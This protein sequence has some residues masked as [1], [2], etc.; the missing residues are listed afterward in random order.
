MKFQQM[1]VGRILLQNSPNTVNLLSVKSV[2]SMKWN[3]CL[4]ISL[5]IFFGTDYTDVTDEFLSWNGTR[6]NKNFGS[7]IF[8]TDVTDGTDQP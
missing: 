4:I 8:D 3:P 5:L 6:V 2:C 1:S 7:K